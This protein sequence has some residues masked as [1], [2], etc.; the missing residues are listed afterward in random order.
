LKELDEPQKKVIENTIEMTD[1]EKD[2]AAQLKLT[3]EEFNKYKKTIEETDEATKNLNKITSEELNDA[4]GGVVKNIN[5]ATASLNNF[6]IAGVA[7]AVASIKMSFVPAVNDLKEVMHNLSVA[8]LAGDISARDY[9]TLEIFYKKQIND[10]L[11]QQAEK[12]N[13]VMDGL[14]EY[15]KIV[16][17]MSNTGSSGGFTV[18][19]YAV[20]TPYVPK[21]E[22]AMVHQGERITPANQNTTNNKS[23]STLNIQPGAIN[24]VT[25]KF[26]SADGQELFRQLERQIK[27]R[28]LKLVRA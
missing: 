21:T 16:A 18:P 10:L 23:T 13:T 26:S 12:V 20:G 9:N 3:E 2:L 5:F 15:N 14:K 11:D 1:K 22:L 8:F 27:M 4:F 7:A 28:G 17:S 19:S 6:T 24:I 25:P